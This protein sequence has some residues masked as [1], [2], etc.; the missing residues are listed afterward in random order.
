[1]KIV[2][3]WPTISGY[4]AA[5]WRELSRRPGVELFVLAFPTTPG[6]YSAFEPGL[7][8]GIPSRMLDQ[9]ERFDY[10]LSRDILMEQAPDVLF[11]SGWQHKPYFRAAL[12]RRIPA[13]RRIMIIDAA[14]KKTLRQLA[15]QTVFPFLLRNIDGVFV[16]GERS[17]PYARAIGFRE[18]DI[19][20]GTYGI[21]WTGRTDV[22]T[23]R[24]NAA[25]WPRAFLFAG[26]YIP[27]KGVDLLLRAY[28]DYRS[29][30]TDPWPLHMC[31]TG[32]LLP[33]G[34][35][36][37]VDHGFVQPEEL[38]RRQGDAGVFVLPSRSDAWPL[39]LVESCAAGLPVICTEACG[40]HVELVRQFHNGIVVP[41]ANVGALTGAMR[42]MHEHHD[43]L[44][45]MGRAAR[46]LAAAYS[47]ERWADRILAACTPG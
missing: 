4:M 23:Q 40:S 42:W 8:E 11:I 15:A 26:Q 37:V 9:S 46:E 20:R 1:M 13:G 33:Q 31:G 43:R 28:A 45:A 25:N 12:D 17:W 36:G 3:C 24:Q 47:T 27:R 2:F 38:R 10:P 22:H 41:T 5:C 39:A 30:V 32:P 35:A 21:D 29:S 14:K 19:Y 34:A 44:P 16:P 6:K 7:L 18:A